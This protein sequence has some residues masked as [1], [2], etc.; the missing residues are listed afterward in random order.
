MET[1]VVTLPARD[2]NWIVDVLE[3]IADSPVRGDSVAHWRELGDQHR[4]EDIL[5][6]M[7]TMRA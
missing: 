2:F 5:V 1:V 6:Q 3:R 7:R 4:A